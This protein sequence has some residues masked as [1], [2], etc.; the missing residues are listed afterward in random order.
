MTTESPP[1][2]IAT[3]ADAI[4]IVDEIRTAQGR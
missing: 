1:L 3:Q 4:R 2:V